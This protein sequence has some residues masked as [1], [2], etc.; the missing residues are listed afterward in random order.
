MNFNATQ[1][2]NAKTPRR[3]DATEV[4]LS[5]ALCIN[6]RGPRG[7]W[8][9]SLRCLIAFSSGV[10]APL[11]LCVKALLISSVVLSAHAAELP[12]APVPK[13]PYIAVVY[14]YAETMLKHGRDTYGPQKTGLFLSALDR[15]TLAPLTNRPTAPKGVWDENKRAG[16]KG[17]PLVGA[18]PQ[19]D[20]NLLRLLY[21]LS[22]LTGKA[23]YREAADAGLKWF[24][25]NA[26]STNTHL[27]PWGD[28]MS[29]DVIND[30]PVDGSG[31]TE[32]SHQFARPWM[33]WDRCFALAPESSRQFALG[34]WEH[35][36]ANHETG[37]FNARAG[38]F[39]HQAYEALD[40]QNH[41]GFY[42]RTWA[43]AYA[44][45][46]SEQFLRPI[47]VLLTRFEKKRHPLTGL[48]EIFSNQANA[49]V[50]WA[51]SF[52]ID[53][54]GAAHH[55]AE[56]LASRLRAFAAREDDIF[57][58]LP[59]D[60]KKTGALIIGLSPPTGKTLGRTHRWNGGYGV[61]TAQL[62][63][64]CVSRYDNTGKAGYRD[65][66]LGAADA[67]LDS[68]PPE[69]EDAWP[70]TFGHAISLQLAAW[71]HSADW[72]YMERA[73]KLGDIA[74]EKFFGTNALPKASFKTDHYE[75]ITGADTLALALAELHLH[76]LHITA[77]RCPPNT[78]DR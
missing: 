20:E 50:D 11:R 75:S 48:I 72:K 28:Y 58:A 51:L 44:H 71:R 67:Y 15:T 36:I 47:N 45:T 34:L 49:R 64:L 35:Q 27:L 38:Y 60:V 12:K 46:K 76:V 59:H 40:F 78:L 33:L 17:K 31:A 9:T 43:A 8:N 10:L 13:S 37:G 4:E 16:A 23:H 22:E 66:I 63:M 26:R 54:E 21:L 74:I 73:R 56:P 70:S 55:I 42:I 29:W 30:Q 5:H 7:R 19:H 2:L 6:R 53:C 68:L 57:C 25:D 39:E 62:A 32:G 3:K 41:A 65:L 69:T 24:L 77:V 61:T 14:R 1:R 18:N 52:A